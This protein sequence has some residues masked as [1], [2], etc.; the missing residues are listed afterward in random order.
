[1]CE[2]DLPASHISC[3]RKRDKRTIDG[4]SKDEIRLCSRMCLTD[5]LDKEAPDDPRILAS[6]VRSLIGE[7]TAKPLATMADGG[8]HRHGSTTIGDLTLRGLISTIKYE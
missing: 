1:M 8:W 6:E 7:V 2:D 4:K 5:F 3:G